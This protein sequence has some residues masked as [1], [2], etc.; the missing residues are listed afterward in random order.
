MFSLPQM[1]RR[2]DLKAGGVRIGQ[3]R[4]PLLFGQGAQH[5]LHLLVLVDAKAAGAENHPVDEAAQFDLV[6]FSLHHNGAVGVYHR[7]SPLRCLNDLPRPLPAL[8]R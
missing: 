6:V 3:H 7:F 4:Q 1:L 2:A 5:L 8:R